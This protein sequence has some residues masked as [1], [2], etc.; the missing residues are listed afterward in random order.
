[1]NLRLPLVA[2]V[3]KTKRFIQLTVCG[4]EVRCTALHLDDVPPHALVADITHILHVP[5][6]PLRDEIVGHWSETPSFAFLEFLVVFH[7]RL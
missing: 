7:L 6:Y 1:M 4:I 3:R 2:E 5:L